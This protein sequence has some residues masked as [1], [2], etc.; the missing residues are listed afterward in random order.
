MRDGLFFVSMILGSIAVADALIVPED[1]SIKKVWHTAVRSQLIYSLAGLVLG[2]A[3]VVG[4]IILFLYGITGSTT[5]AAKLVGAESNITDAAPGAVLF[6][7][8]LFV[9]WITRFDV[10]VRKS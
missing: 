1:F 4:G 6:I 8:G 2:L 5:W 9:V 10:K 3:C 7:V